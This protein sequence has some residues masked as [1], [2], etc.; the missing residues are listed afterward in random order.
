[1]KLY[2]D[3]GHGGKDPGAMGD[4][5]MEK[6]IN[7]DIALR[8]R[9]IL[10]N[11][12]ENVEVRMSRTDDRTISLTERTDEA[13][14]WSADYY[15]SIHCNAFD[16]KSNGYE[17]FIH[18]SLSN[19]SITAK[20]QDI[21]HDEVMKIN[22]LKD[23][24]QK[25]ANFHVLRE[26]IMPALLT[27]NGFVDNKSDA[28]LLKQE[29]WRE[30]VARGHV[31]G[32]A[33]AFNLQLKPIEVNQ[34]Y[35]VI[36]G[37]FKL[38]DNADDRVTYLSS[39]G[40]PAF[41]EPVLI[42]GNQFHRVQAGAFLE[43]KNAEQRLEQVKQAGIKDAYII[44]PEVEVPEQ[45][46]YP[47]LGPTTLSP[48]QMNQFVKSVNP[49]AIEIGWYYVLYGQYYGIRGDIAFAQAILETDY[50]RF[51]GIVEPDQNNFCGL[52]ATSA[53]NPGARFDTP[54]QGVLAHIQHLYA[55]TSSSPLPDK[56]PLEDPR[57]RLVT[58]NSA[59]KWEALNGKWAVP[60]D[61]YGQ[62]ILNIYEK[63]LGASIKNI[64]ETL[65]DVKTNRK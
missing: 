54:E 35:K 2:L 37:S 23:R 6:D 3:P 30:K 52:G 17:D 36:A 4:G 15:L 56:Y 9:S 44:N 5:I 24:G 32:L 1:M 25:K 63:M 48:E 21:I 7:L 53:A 20:Y 29:S 11:N 13:N 28:A 40:I 19:S 27:E 60:G 8:I 65:Q 41:V 42:D 22:G 10:L 55:Y 47:I 58:R 51:T 49:D 16:G 18:N 34:L 64:E 57:F 38:R 33:K 39:K 31:N 26:S 12:Y 46:G 59:T 45:A 50:L 62:L 14:A 43:K 61:N